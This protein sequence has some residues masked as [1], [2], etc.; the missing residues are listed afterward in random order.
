MLVGRILRLGDRL[1]VR[2]ELIDVIDGWQVWGDQYHAEFSDIL[3]VQQDLTAAISERVR[4]RL[5]LADEHAR[6][7]IEIQAKR[8]CF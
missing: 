2:T 5:S 6:G 8:R 1:I 3:S 4:T 7:P